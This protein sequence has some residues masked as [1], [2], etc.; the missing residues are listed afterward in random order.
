[1]GIVLHAR[2]DGSFTILE[3]R[4][5]SLSWNLWVQSQLAIL[6][7]GQPLMSA[8][9]KSSI[10]RDQQ[11]SNKIAGKMLIPRRLRREGPNAIEAKQAEFRSQ[12]EITVGRLSNRLDRTFGKA[13]ADLPGR[14]RVLVDIERWV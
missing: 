2:P 9:P 7:T 8:N 11:P 5:N 6:P 10:A 4:I 12:P 14:M 1:V 3:E 13:F